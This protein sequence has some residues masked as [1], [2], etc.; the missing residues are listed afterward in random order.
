VLFSP[1]GTVGRR[2]DFRLIDYLQ[3]FRTGEWTY[4]EHT[5]RDFHR[6]RIT[7]WK[8]AHSLSLLWDAGWNFRSWYVDLQEPLRRTQLGF[9]TRDQALDVVVEPDG[10]WQW[11]DEDHL[12][13]LTRLGAFTSAE[14]AAIHAEGERVID[15]RPW[16]TGWEDWRP[17]PT[18][19]LPQL[20][21]DWDVV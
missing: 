9:D 4:V 8:R 17:D 16:P 12:A 15:E 1:I 14:A 21:E 19:P 5:W 3:Q 6:L 13:E 18:W 10:S 11:K 7:Q 20:P 2:P